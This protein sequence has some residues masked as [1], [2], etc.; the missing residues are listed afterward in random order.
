MRKVTCRITG[1]SGYSHEFYKAPNGKY[2]KNKELYD[3][4]MVQKETKGKIFYLINSDILNKHPS[5]CGSL[6]GK[7]I[8]ETGLEPDVIY[9]S[10]LQKM[11]YIK[12]VINES[13]ESDSTKIH[14]IF[15]IATKRLNRTTYAGCYE[16]RNNKTNTVYIGESINLFGRFTEHISELYGNKH[17]CKALQDAFNETKSISDFT[18]TPL[19]MFPISAIDKNE[20]KQETLYLESAFYIIAKSN[21]EEIYN[22]NNPYLALK[23]NSVTLNGYEIDCKRVLNLLASDKYSVLPTKLLKT[24]RRNLQE[25]GLLNVEDINRVDNS[26]VTTLPSLVKNDEPQITKR[27]VTTDDYKGIDL[28]N[29]EKCIERTKDLLKDNV[30]L[31]RITHLLKELASDGI[32]PIDYDYSKIREILIEKNLITIDSIRQTVATNYALENGYYFIASVSTKKEE[33]TYGYYVSEKLKQ[34][35][36]DIFSQYKNIDDLKRVS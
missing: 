4:M 21:H 3:N 28:S 12:K 36:I 9:D 33:P 32:I 16:I 29:I 8:N 6:I 22:T 15:S 30:K 26:S 20:L 7:L 17:H 13:D 31:Y 35:L 23:N 14:L 1:E 2:Y 18:I 10:I 11:D 34:L 24:I 27:D 5:N 25:D 19:F